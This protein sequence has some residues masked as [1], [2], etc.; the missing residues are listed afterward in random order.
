M[1]RREFVTMLG[2]S[3]LQA[4]REPQSD[5]RLKG[6]FRRP[7]QSGWIY[8]HL[9]GTPAE[10]GFQHGWLLAAEI[11]EA[12]QVTALELTHDAKR[13]WAF[14]REIAQKELSPRIENQYREEREGCQAGEASST[15]GER[16]K[17]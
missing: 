9:E 2:A 1:R 11:K 12:L 4:A 10:I 17:G 6:A 7:K 3:A 15:D 13:P 5:P 16:E 8:V 14:F